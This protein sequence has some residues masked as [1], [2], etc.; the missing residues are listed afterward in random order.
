VRRF[1]LQHAPT[2]I[3]LRIFTLVHVVSHW[4]HTPQPKNVR[5]PEVEFA[6]GDA[7]W[8]RIPFYDSALVSSADG[9]GKQIYVRDRARFRSMLVETIRLHATLWW[10][11]PTL[12]RQY[13]RQLKNVTSAQTWEGI[14]S[15]T[16]GSGTPG[17]ADSVAAGSGTAGS[18]AAGSAPAGSAG[19]ASVRPSSG[20]GK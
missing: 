7:N 2:G 13:R 10:N 4:F 16:A 5:T 3:P 20:G 8:W 14:F 12:A 17:T 18:V 9:G 19:A 1:T 11:W 6:K 15:G